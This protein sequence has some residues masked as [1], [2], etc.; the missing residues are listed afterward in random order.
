MQRASAVLSKADITFQEGLNEDLAATALWGAQQ[1][2][3]RGEGRFDGTYGGER[4][5]CRE[6]LAGLSQ[7]ACGARG[8]AASVFERVI[9]T[10]GFVV[11][12]GGATVVFLTISRLNHD[13]D[14]NARL[15]WHAQTARAAILCKQPIRA[16]TEIT[17]NYGASGERRAPPSGGA[18]VGGA[19]GLNNGGLRHVAGA[20]VEDPLRVLRVA[21]FAARYAGRGFAVAPET[22]DLMR[23]ISASGE[24]ESEKSAWRAPSSSIA[25]KAAGDIGGRRVPLPLLH[26]STQSF[27]LPVSALNEMRQ[28]AFFTMPLARNSIRHQPRPP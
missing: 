26:T 17:L 3:L 11:E 20:L 24:L 6:L 22:V 18:A 4:D 10:N 9:E 12:G 28:A 13:C 1:A 7:H 23:R 25:A 8:S 15:Q 16:G 27:S 5:H 14:S 21:R 2:E 19:Q